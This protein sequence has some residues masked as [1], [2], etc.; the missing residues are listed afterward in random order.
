MKVLTTLALLLFTTALVAQTFNGTGGAITDDGQNNDFIINVS[1]LSQPTID[2]N[3]GLLQV[4]LDIT[5]TYDADLEVDLIAPDGTIIGLFSRIGGG[6]DNF[7]G[8]CLEEGAPTPIA[9][10]SAPFTGSF[11]PMDHLGAVNNGQIG[12]GNWT[13]RVRDTWA[14]DFGTL[15]NWS[16]TFGPNAPAPI[17]VTSS[18]LPIIIVET[19]G[20]AIPDEP[21]VDGTMKIIYNG[22]GQ[23]NFVTDPANDY[24]G[25]IGIEIR[26]SFSASLPQKPYGIE[27][28][29]ITNQDTNVSLLGMPKEEDWILQAT[30][31]DKSFMRNTLAQH[32]F[33]EMGHYG[34]R[35]RH[36]E[37]IVNG[38]YKGIYILMEKIKRDNDRVDI[39]KL[40]SSENSGD[41]MT[42]GYIF[43]TDY[44]GWNDS[45]ESQY[46]PIDHPSLD[47]HFV[48]YY[49]KPEKITGPQKTYLESYVDQYETAL[50]GP[51]FT[52]PGLGYAEY[53]DVNSFVDYFIINELSRN[54]D[55][56]KKSRYY[57]KDRDSTYGKIMAGPVW[58][59]D[60]AWTDVDECSIFAATD[61]SGWAHHIND[62]NPDVNS[63]GWYI[64]MMQ[65]TN[66][67][68]A[69]YCRWT[70]FRE[71]I[72]DTSYLFNYIDS[73]TTY[74]DSAQVRHY[75]KWGTLGIDVG[76]PEVGQVP[77]DYQG[78]MDFFKDWI[79]ERIAW[80]DDNITGYCFSTGIESERP[81]PMLSVFPNPASDKVY[82]EGISPHEG[83]LLLYDLTGKQV[84]FNALKIDS[85]YEV[86]VST[87]PAGAYFIQW[88][89]E[90]GKANSSA[91]KLIIAR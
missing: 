26:G 83:N 16:I 21:K 31:N 22:P 82:V 86:D 51:D 11:E 81:S 40:D 61:G 3:H 36:C 66:F 35:Y 71:T 53:I 72:L 44:W 45:W 58:D 34:V 60:W 20:Q 37:L 5:H 63:P 38:S 29:T 65:D 10:G 77:A 90:D 49:P 80:L 87:L 33:E 67:V 76:T 17:T 27:T 52:T 68:N 69:L 43:K 8:T 46:N 91:K 30:Y 18:N 7:T 74:L 14:Q 79:A 6:D 56:F 64:K 57:H 19:G 12:N 24:D 28:R 78:D 2:A 54:N 42:G 39:A 47:V 62:C 55:G 41:A 25:N 1:G 48:Y 4:C 73:V 88:I 13:L 9:M 84:K 89:S 59:F 50:Y 23:T 15:N 75:E 32:L 70:L 85:H